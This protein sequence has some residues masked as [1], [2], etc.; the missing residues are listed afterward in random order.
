MLESPAYLP[1]NLDAKEI[2]EGAIEWDPSE[3]TPKDPGKE[4]L[5]HESD[6]L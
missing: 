3:S 6:S 1:E 4:R 2:I 5:Y